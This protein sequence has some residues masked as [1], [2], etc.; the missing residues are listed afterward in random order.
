MH[1]LYASPFSCSLAVHLVLAQRGLPHELKW[2]DRGQ[3]R[4]IRQ[5][6]LARINPFRKVPT[7]LRPDGEV[8]TEVSSILLSL[9]PVEAGPEARSPAQTRALQAWI[10][11]VATELHKPLLAPAF[12]ADCPALVWQDA[13]DRLIPHTLEVVD[14][15][16][17]QAD[18][19]LA[20]PTPSAADAYLFWALTLIRFR[21]PELLSPNLARFHGAYMAQPWVGPVL[22]I[23][24]SARAERG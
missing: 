19:L 8:T 23:E 20:E 11:V 18:T 22:A 14:A 16:L 2:V 4:L 10:S 13:L 3:G 15:H 5:R 21:W 1:T 24:Q 17:T 7:L 9:D 12:D 6:D